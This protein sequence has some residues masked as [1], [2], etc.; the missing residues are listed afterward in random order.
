MLTGAEGVN[1]GQAFLLGKSLKY[2]RREFLQQIGYCPQFDSII[3]VLT[4]QEMLELFAALRGIPKSQTE[5]EIQKWMRFL[6]KKRADFTM[7]RHRVPTN[8]T[9]GQHK[10]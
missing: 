3:E 9:K 6:R 2:Q 5:A 4:G 7:S 8:V 10:N 1:E